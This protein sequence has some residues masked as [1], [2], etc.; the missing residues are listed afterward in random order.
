MKGLQLQISP[1][2]SFI[3]HWLSVH[4]AH[5][6]LSSDEKAF[7]RSICP[8]SLYLNLGLS[9]SQLCTLLRLSPSFVTLL[10]FHSRLSQF[11]PVIAPRPL[12]HRM[13]LSHFFH[14]LSVS[15][16]FFFSPQQQVKRKK[17]EN[18]SAGR[19]LSFIWS[20]SFSAAA[21]RGAPSH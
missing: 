16:S 13:P 21:K 9:F 17:C 19:P 12:S 15:A 5:N 1:V 3:S 14:P 20:L 10:T 11:L 8:L 2:F 4:R 7:S 6:K 18:S